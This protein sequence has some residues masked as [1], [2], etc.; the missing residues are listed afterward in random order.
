PTAFAKCLS[1]GVLDSKSEQAINC[2][3]S[4]AGK[5]DKTLNCIFGTQMTPQQRRIF[6]CAASNKDYKSVGICIVESQMSREQRRIVECATENKGSY[7]QMGLCVAGD[8]LTAEQKVFAQCAISTG[9]QPYAF[10]GCVGTQLTL[11]EIDKCFSKGIGGD[12]CFGK[13]NT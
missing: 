4:N 13:N 2:A 8:K 1:S 6:D 3:I 9:G 10:A 12:G 7:L 5:T 11:N